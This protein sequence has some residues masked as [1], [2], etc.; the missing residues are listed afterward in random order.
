MYT[1]CHRWRSGWMGRCD[2]THIYQS[3]WDLEVHYD[4]ILWSNMYIGICGIMRKESDRKLLAW[5]MYAKV[6]SCNWLGC[7]AKECAWWTHGTN[8]IRERWYQCAITG[9]P[10]WHVDPH[11][12]GVGWAHI[13]TMGLIELWWGGQH[14]IG[15]TFEL[16]QQHNDKWTQLFWFI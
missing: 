9:F 7:V 13:A 2:I 4:H 3:W 12:I 14:A 8:C 6:H 10:L 5:S 16:R 11:Y 15:S 1:G